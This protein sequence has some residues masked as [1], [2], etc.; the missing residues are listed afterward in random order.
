M[1]HLFIIFSILLLSSPLF[2]DNH[3]GETLYLWK[4]SSSV[5]WY[6]FGNKYTR[7]Q[8]KGE[9]ENGK[10]N[11]LGVLIYPYNGK[12]IVGEWKNGKEWKTKHRTKNGSLILKFEM[13]KNGQVTFTSPD[14]RKYVGEWKDGKQNGQGKITLPDGEK[15]E[16]KFKDGIPNGQGTYISPD[17]R[18]YVGEFKDGIPNGQGT[19]I[20][21]DGRM[22]V[23]EW[24]DGKTKWSRNI[25][26]PD[27]TKYVGEWKDGKTW[28]GTEYDKNGNIIG[29]WVNGVLQK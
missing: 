5:Q 18:M 16:G 24:K 4:T 15:Y 27:G 10:P 17:G 6:R 22:D 28:N 12:S 26:F 7:P 3:K 1:K 14:G 20:S 25:H 13:G 8:Y 11:G 23:G 2:G 29:K 19:Y 9:V 21:P